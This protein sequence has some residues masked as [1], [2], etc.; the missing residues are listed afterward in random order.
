M[1]TKMDNQAGSTFKIRMY[2]DFFQAVN[3]KEIIKIDF[4]F[5][6]NSFPLN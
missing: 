2:E 5:F 1:D 6:Q 3:K 4:F